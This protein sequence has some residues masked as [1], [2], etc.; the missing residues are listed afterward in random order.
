MSKCLKEPDRSS[1]IF[2]LWSLLT[3]LYLFL[4]LTVP[5]NIAPSSSDSLSA[6]FLDLP[7]IDVATFSRLS[8]EVDAVSPQVGT[9]T[10]QVDAVTPQIDAVTPQINAVTGQSPTAVPVTPNNAWET[11]SI[12]L[13]VGEEVIRSCVTPRKVHS[14]QEALRKEA[15]RHRCAV[16]LLPYFFSKEE[17]SSS[18]TDGTHGK[19]SLDS[20]KL[21]SI[22]VLV[23]SKFPV[24]S[25]AEK[26]KLWRFIKTKINARCHASK[27]S[28]RDH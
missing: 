13:P 4:Q 16:R 12:E 3:F 7:T 1:R 19:Q 25:A 17:L 6:T 27:F 18:N 5:D 24:E 11:V 15:D 8:G 9:V 20:S 28:T 10:P 2:H 21:N 14:V 26:D 23:F 22:K